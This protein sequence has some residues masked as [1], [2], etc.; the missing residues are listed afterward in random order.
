MRAYE[1]LDFVPLGR[2]YRWLM[3]FFHLET[4]GLLFHQNRLLFCFFF[5]LL[6]FS[7]DQFLKD[8]VA[9]ASFVNFFVKLFLA[10]HF[11]LFF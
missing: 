1:L 4:V 9:K 11:L 6:V 3:P 7:V 5:L 8:Q 10:K 2:V